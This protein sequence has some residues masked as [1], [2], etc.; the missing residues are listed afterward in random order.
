LAF[1]DR[2]SYIKIVCRDRRDREN[3]KKKC[4]SE[5]THVDGGFVSS[6]RSM[7]V[8]ENPGRPSRPLKLPQ[9][10]GRSQK[11]ERNKL[12]KETAITIERQ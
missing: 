8:V 4:D 7:K 3:G 12:K 6:P 5:W 11:S 10:N 1:Y 2:D 9:K